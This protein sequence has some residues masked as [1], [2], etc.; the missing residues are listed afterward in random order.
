M[1]H[2]IQ[3][4]PVELNTML[5]KTYLHTNVKTYLHDYSNATRLQLDCIAS[6]L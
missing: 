4:R 1:L 6:I 3:R 5:L 2:L